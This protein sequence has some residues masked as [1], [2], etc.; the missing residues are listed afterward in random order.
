[1]FRLNLARLDQMSLKRK[2]ITQI[3]YMLSSP[4]F[5][6]ALWRACIEVK[7]L[8]VLVLG[9]IFSGLVYA[10]AV[11]QFSPRNIFIYAQH[12]FLFYLVI[13]PI[14][15]VIWLLVSSIIVSPKDPSIYRRQACRLENLAQWAAGFLII[16]LLMLFWATFT[17]IKNTLS[18]EG[19]TNDVMLANVERWLH[20]GIDPTVWMATH[21]TNPIFLQAVQFNYN[22]IWQILHLL[23]VCMVILCPA[24]RRMRLFYMTMYVVGWLVLG[25]IIAGLFISGGPTYYAEVTG[26]SER[27]APLETLLETT[28]TDP[29]STYHLQQYL[30]T[31]YTLGRSDLGSGISAFPSI[32]IYIVALNA[33]FLYHFLSRRLGVIAAFYA[34]FCLLSSAY[35]GWHY[36]IDGYASIVFALSFF[37][38]GLRWWKHTNISSSA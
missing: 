19:F 38:V 1:M 2:K 17:Q 34:G 7:W 11:D 6:R 15:S 35:L 12:F 36:L 9:Y 21:F 13:L 27:Y 5:L 24:F 28:K 16:L 14:T 18:T 31:A 25:N 23:V 8:F 4:S 20:G 22:I 37:Y 10:I 29:H 33:L 32:H 30:W 26:D 3:K